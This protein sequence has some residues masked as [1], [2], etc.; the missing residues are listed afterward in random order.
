M[1]SLVLS[2]ASALICLLVQIPPQGE[3]LTGESG[4]LELVPEKLDFGVGQKGKTLYLMITGVTFPVQSHVVNLRVILNYQDGSTDV[5]NMV[6]PFDIGDCWSKWCGRFHDTAANGF[7][8]IGGKTGP[9]GSAV[10]DDITKP[11][12]VK[13]TEAQLVPFELKPD[14]ELQSVTLEAIANDVIFGVMG[15][16]I[17]K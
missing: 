8:N 7:E 15:A 12:N 1:T 3:G 13:E 10:V 16:S 17:L 11:I 6:S 14:V 9:A 5:R 2:F 4:A